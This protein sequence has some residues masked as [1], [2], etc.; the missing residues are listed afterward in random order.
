MLEKSL[1]KIS[2]R[3][4]E[5]N[6]QKHTILVCRKG[7]PM[8]IVLKTQ[9]QIDG[10]K[11]SSKLAAQTL[12]FIAPFVV[13][14]VTTI[15]LNDLIDS[16]IRGHNAIPAPLDY[17][18][19]PKSICTSVNEVICHGIPNETVLKEGDIINI[20]VTTILDGYYGDT[21]RMYAVGNVSLEAAKIIAATHRCLEIGI[22]QVKPGNRIGLIGHE[23]AKFAEGLGYSVVESFGGHGTGLEFHEEPFI[24]HKSDPNVG[25]TMQPGMVFTIE[26]MICEK[27]ADVVIDGWV[28]STKD[29]GL[30]A[31]FEH[32]VAV[33]ENGVEILTL[34][35]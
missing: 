10:I 24:I 25:A 14:G 20:D 12:D 18:G 23:I 19:Y 15:H 11:K 8:S 35:D 17:K 28:A 16:Y 3:T 4:L 7:E 29:K 5:L 32:T 21:S 26:P 6:F 30:S 27:A 13:P 22:E 31:Q 34:S 2:Q 9:E 1:R 33:T